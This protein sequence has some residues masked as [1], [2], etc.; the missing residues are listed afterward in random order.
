MLVKV[1]K[2]GYPVPVP[3]P[4]FKVAEYP[5]IQPPVRGRSELSPYC[6]RTAWLL[7]RPRARFPPRP[8]CRLQSTVLPK[9]YGQDDR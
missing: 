8:L 1:A 4:V 3:Y 2:A 9:K 7:S 5:A 6:G